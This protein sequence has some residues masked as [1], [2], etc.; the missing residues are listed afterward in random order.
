LYV[1]ETA[2]DSSNARLSVSLVDPGVP[3]FL[4]KMSASSLEYLAKAILWPSGRRRGILV[5]AATGYA[6][7]PGAIGVHHVY[8]RV[9]LHLVLP[10]DPTKTT[11]G[12][13]PTTT[14]SSVL[15]PDPLLGAT[16]GGDGEDARSA[17]P[18]VVP[19]ERY[20]AVLTLGRPR[21]PTPPPASARL[22]PTT[23]PRP[24]RHVSLT[25][26]SCPRSPPFVR[27]RR[28]GEERRQLASPN[29]SPSKHDYARHMS[30]AYRKLATFVGHV[31]IRA[32]VSERGLAFAR[33]NG[34][35]RIQ[36]AQ[37]QVAQA[38][39][40]LVDPH[41]WRRG[42]QGAALASILKL[43]SNRLGSETLTPP[44]FARAS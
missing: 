14:G 4:V 25:A 35:P 26:S 16:L 31:P 42:A 17:L 11:S 19:G 8:V 38:R 37:A 27:G 10:G 5:G 39:L 34:D 44:R 21:R 32:S 22:P 30:G 13:R 43:P 2:T 18:E 20:L 7:H 12:R 41:R 15:G 1:G 6:P 36:P 3:I 33:V 24:A 40:A 29:P 23:T 9:E 28:R